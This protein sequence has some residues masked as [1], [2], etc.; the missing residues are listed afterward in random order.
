MTD[1]GRLLADLNAAGARYVVIGGIAVIRHGVVRATKDV[2][3]VVAVGDATLD[4]VREL[5]GGWQATRPDGSVFDA[6]R[7]PTAGWPWQLA[8]RYGLIDI[9][10]DAAPPLDLAGMLARADERR[11]EGVPAPVCSLAD[12]VALKR[13]A[14]RPQDIEDLRQLEIAHGSLPDLPGI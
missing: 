5:L 4:R 2:D 6:S 3:I 13:R 7:T 11:I 10:A 9:L 1:F 12:L 8:T 14:G